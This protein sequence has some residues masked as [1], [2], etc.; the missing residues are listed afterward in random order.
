MYIHLSDTW[1]DPNKSTFCKESTA[2]FRIHILKKRKGRLGD[3][4]MCKALAS[5]AYGSEFGAPKLSH[6]KS[7]TVTHDCNSR[8]SQME[9]ED[10]GF[11]E[12]CRAHG[13]VL[14]Q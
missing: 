7:I 11:K 6:K 12:A 14:G 9:G 13:K 10:K 5:Q 2:W 4:S 8:D 1:P 3:G